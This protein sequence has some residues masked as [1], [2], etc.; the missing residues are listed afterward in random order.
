MRVQDA[1]TGLMEQQYEGTKLA[2]K[3]VTV[4]LPELL[5]V[6]GSAP[7]PAVAPTF[8]NTPT[9]I[10]APSSANLS[11][12]VFVSL[13]LFLLSPPT[14]TSGIVIADSTDIK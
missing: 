4:F 11:R 7:T 2:D 1:I 8:W 13:S 5:P 10:Q 12:H 3:E 9:Q 14:P 6:Q